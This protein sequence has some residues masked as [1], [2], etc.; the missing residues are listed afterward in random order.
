MVH[1]L[2]CVEL[3]IGSVQDLDIGIRSRSPEL[4]AVGPDRFEDD[5]VEQEFVAH[6]ESG[7]TAEQPVK[8]GESDSEVFPLGKKCACAM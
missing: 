7:L 2:S 6:R 1:Q 5:L 4:Y 3:W 8:L